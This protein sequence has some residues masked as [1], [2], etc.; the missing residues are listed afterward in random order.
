MLIASNILVYIVALLLAL[1]PNFKIR[2]YFSNPLYLIILLPPICYYFYGMIRTDGV[3]FNTYLNYFDDTDLI[4]DYIF[5]L[6]VNIMN[7]FSIN[8]T[9]FFAIQALVTVYAIYKLSYI[10]KASFV[11]VLCI[12]LIHSAVV[13]DFSQ[14]RI[15]LA[16]SC[17]F[18][19]YS[20]N[21]MIKK[22]V[23]AILAIGIHLSSIFPLLIFYFCDKIVN[24]SKAKILIIII[25][26]SILS[27]LIR[28]E[29][30][31][32][33][34]LFDPRVDAYIN[35]NTE[36][37]GAQVNNFNN[38]IFN[39]LL[40]FIGYVSFYVTKDIIYF[41]FSLYVLLGIIFFFIL[42]DTS[43]FAYRLTHLTTIFYPFI[44]S[45]IFVDINKI[46]FIKYPLNFILIK[47]TLLTS[48]LIL[49]LIG[50][51]SNIGDIL[52]KVEPYIKFY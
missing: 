46:S 3:D 19:I 49:L 8:L 36:Y 41:K 37:Y 48:S 47:L 27:L 16:V 34:S 44:I 21:S 40:S 26:I 4:N 17:I 20:S 2:E 24:L 6:I 51:R 52:T 39:I 10:Y 22:Y 5:K 9:T 30:F 18:L 31:F 7:Y 14:S 42:S 15:A 23:F 43:I 29:I 1:S 11:L 35:W 28:S 38:L 12:F 25:V 50:T 13:R 33:I 45:K 32:I